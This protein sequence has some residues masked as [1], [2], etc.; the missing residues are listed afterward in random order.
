MFVIKQTKNF[1]H[2]YLFSSCRIKCC[3]YTHLTD[4]GVRAADDRKGWRKKE[5][6]LV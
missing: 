5:V 3:F 6:T 4:K 1:A 2:F